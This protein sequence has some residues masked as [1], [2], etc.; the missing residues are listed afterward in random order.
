MRDPRS[1]SEIGDTLQARLRSA[2]PSRATET[3]GAMAVVEV[4]SSAE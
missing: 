1:L 4:D 3:I 2:R